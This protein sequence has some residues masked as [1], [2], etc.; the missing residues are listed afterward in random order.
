MKCAI[1]VRSASRARRLVRFAYMRDAYDSAFLINM[2]VF[3]RYSLPQ[4]S[5][6]GARWRSSRNLRRTLRVLDSSGAFA[7]DMSDS[8]APA[9]EMGCSEPGRWGR[10]TRRPCCGRRAKENAHVGLGPRFPGRRPDR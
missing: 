2:G 4:S 5:M 8:N 9:L 10:L 7:V 6:T 1:R 3:T